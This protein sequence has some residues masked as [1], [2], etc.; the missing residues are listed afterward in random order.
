MTSSQN[1]AVQ[2]GGVNKSPAYTIPQ[3][4]TPNLATEVSKPSGIDDAFWSELTFKQKV[5]VAHKVL[6]VS[7]YRK[8]MV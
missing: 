4:P 8:E 5:V 7:E 1:V 3:K 6:C 2:F